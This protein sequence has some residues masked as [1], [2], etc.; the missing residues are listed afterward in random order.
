M[1]DSALVILAGHLGCAVEVGMVDG[2]VVA[3][4]RLG[5]GQTQIVQGTV[6]ATTLWVT[7]EVRGDNAARAFQ[8]MYTTGSRVVCQGH[9]V[10]TTAP[11]PHIVVDQV[12]A[13]GAEPPST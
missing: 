3:R 9:L 5:I 12:L 2:Q 4:T 10:P 11:E 13:T 6:R 7:L 8:R 1:Q